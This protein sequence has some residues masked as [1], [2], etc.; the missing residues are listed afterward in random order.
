MGADLG[1]GD[2]PVRE[3]AAGGV[4]IDAAEH[5][6]EGDRAGALLEVLQGRPEVRREPGLGRRLVRLRGRAREA[7]VLVEVGAD[8]R[9]ERRELPVEL[10]VDQGTLF[11]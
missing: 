11:C 4:E 3:A 7:D 6:R 1:L 5:V 9:V 8:A 10:C 2:G